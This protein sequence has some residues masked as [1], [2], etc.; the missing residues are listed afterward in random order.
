MA[1]PEYSIFHN[2]ETIY[3]FAPWQL[4]LLFIGNFLGEEVYFRGYLMKKSAFLG[5]HNWW[6]HSVL[7]TIYHFWQIPMTYALGA[8]SLSFG[9]LMHW[10]K[11]LFELILLH[12]LINLL[13]PI[14]AQLI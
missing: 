11:N 8:I 9:L 13:M 12:V 5:M 10:R 14:L 3:S 1:I 7:F 2:Y 6:V 4:A